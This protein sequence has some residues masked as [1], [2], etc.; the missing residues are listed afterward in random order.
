MVNIMEDRRV[1]STRPPAAETASDDDVLRRVI[2]EAQDAL[3]A[4]AR[5]LKAAG[6][7]VDDL[8]RRDAL[9][10][11]AGVSDAVRKLERVNLP[12]GAPREH[13][14]R[15]VT[16]LKAWLSEKERHLRF[17]FGRDL[18]EAATR[19]GVACAPLTTD[20]PEFR[21]GL[22]T[23]G[24]DFSRRVAILRYARND[25]ATLPLNADAIL[26]ACQK[27]HA[28]LEGTRFD[29]GAFFEQFLAA[30]QVRLHRLGLSFGNRIDVVDL[31]GELA[32]LRQD[33]SFFE[34]PRREDFIPYSRVQL[35]YDLA[36][37]RR[38]GRLSHRGVRVA[39]GSATGGSTR[40]KQRVLYLEDERGNGQWYLSVRFT[41]E[42]EPQEASESGSQGSVARDEAAV[43]P[44]S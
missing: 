33:P 6:K 24:V 9:A 41:R 8:G 31:L 5:Q 7:L 25:L 38:A 37:L 16:V 44:D 13:V 42:E 21:L 40:Q 3:D 32:F 20:P 11:L 10:D 43:S 23:V 35:A 2:K 1:P 22:F 30:Y 28:F 34:N 27:Q 12:D 18:R 4:L 15:L 36:R 26:E 19:A 39:L 29:P 17:H 14:S